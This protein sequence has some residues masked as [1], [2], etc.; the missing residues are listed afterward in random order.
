MIFVELL[1]NFCEH[2]LWVF[3]CFSVF[4]ILSSPPRLIFSLPFHVKTKCKQTKT[5]KKSSYYIISRNNTDEEKLQKLSVLWYKVWTREY[6]GL[7]GFQWDMFSFLPEPI[8]N[9][10][11]IWSQFTVIDDGMKIWQSVWFCRFSFSPRPIVG[12][13]WIFLSEAARDTM[14][15][16]RRLSGCTR[17]RRRWRGLLSGTI[18]AT[19]RGQQSRSPSPQWKMRSLLTSWAIGSPTFST[20]WGVKESVERILKAKLPVSR[21]KWVRIYP[22]KY[23]YEALNCVFE[24]NKS[25]LKCKQMVLSRE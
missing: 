15:R 19:S 6:L 3:F 2:A 20:W 12:R 24:S 21:Q 13:S 9:L 11:E 23:Y 17:P 22:F 1:V 14:K 5:F 8:K 25:S 4:F 18:L 16:S 10:W 7:K